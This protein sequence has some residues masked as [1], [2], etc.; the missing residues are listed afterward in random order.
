V[1]KSE[2]EVVF[3]R[4]SVPKTE[5]RTSHVQHTCFVHLS[6]ID[7]ITVERKKVTYKPVTVHA[8]QCTVYSVQ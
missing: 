7:R 5:E 6:R 8:V 4:S 3:L 2:D 1:K